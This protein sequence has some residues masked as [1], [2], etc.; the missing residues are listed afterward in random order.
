VR[1][2]TAV[3]L[4]LV[5]VSGT[6]AGAAEMS[7]GSS[8]HHLREVVPFE[9]TNP[10]DGTVLRGHVYL[11]DTPPG[12]R[13]GTVLVSSPYW[14]TAG[15]ATDELAN[16]DGTLV[17]RWDWFLA[18]GFAFAAVSLRGTGDS[19]GCVTF[20]GLPDQQDGYHVVEGLAAQ[21]WSNGKV[22]M[23]GLSFDGWSQYMAL[24]AHTPSLK[25]I[26]PVSGVIDYW[27][28]VTRNGASYVSG[29]IAYPVFAG[30]TTTG[31]T[32]PLGGE[33]PRTSPA[34]LACP[35]YAPDAAENA[36]VVWNGDRSPYWEERSYLDEIAASDV[37]VFV[38][39]GL[40]RVRISNAGLSAEGEGHILQFEDL[41]ERLPPGKRRLLVGPWSD[42]FPLPDGM[43][44]AEA[45]AWFRPMVIEWFD[46][47]LRDDAAGRRSF[48]EV[49][50][51][52]DRGDWH[53]G[54]AWPP[55][56][57]EVALPLSG[58]QLLA[59]G[60]E[61]EPGARTSRSGVH[62][63][64]LHDPD[65][66]RC[67]DDYVAYASPALARDV[68]LAGNFVADLTIT[69]TLP[70]GNLA[71][72]LYA[73]DGEQVCPNPTAREFGRALTDLRHWE[74]TGYGRD[75]PVG[76]PTRIPLRSEPFATTVKAG[77][78]IVLVVAGDATELLTDPRKPAL[79]VGAG[80]QHGS[81]LR[82]PVV[83]GRL[84]FARPGRGSAAGSGPIQPG[85]RMTIIDV[86]GDDKAIGS[87]TLGFVFDGVGA[88]AGTTY[89][90]TAAHC[91]RGVG[92]DVGL[93]GTGEVFGDVAVIGDSSSSAT[94][95]ALIAVRPDAEP[96]VSAA[97]RGHPQ[98]PQGSTVPGT[99]TAGD[100]VQQTDLGAPRQGELVD[101]DPE[102]Y[103]IAGPV[104]PFDSGGPLAHVPSAGGLGLV[105][106]GHDCALPSLRCASY[107]GPTVQGILAKAAAA[108]FPI[109]LRSVSPPS[110]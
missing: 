103:R 26:V 75:F 11:P 19:G 4:V 101:D 109:A 87:C 62:Q 94:D 30:Q 104:I 100:V 7:A 42:G 44:R 58:E 83:E 52:D 22:G 57:V 110:S 98:Y 84:A 71:A 37:R 99:T 72:F 97:M 106:R 80:P 55:R 102:T 17:S 32:R 64:G 45:D 54:A 65:L 60:E 33:E 107:S 63:L 74:Y 28:I 29:P 16:A 91:V 88:R 96:R 82:L 95:W 8:R 86:E 5:M 1:L 3:A 12:E 15:R 90:S 46:A 51:Q 23:F 61:P 6:T 9:V 40:K 36:S 39:N 77:Q 48:D 41:W 21:P 92:Q 108:G 70:D 76:V 105:S 78:R 56:S 18:E 67:T 34:H 38:V 69:S 13:V 73:V 59:P 81:T 85:A 14:G 20:G 49:R 66:Q 47:Y 89:V 93:L 31:V 10:N 25:A 79:T 27:S 35:Q 43:T 50:Y 53:L 68:H 2:L 24:A